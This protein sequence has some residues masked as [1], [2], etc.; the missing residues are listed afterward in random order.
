MATVQGLQAPCWC[1]IRTGSHSWG[2]NHLSMRGVIFIRSQVFIYGPNVKSLSNRH[3][4]FITSESL[5]GQNSV[6]PKLGHFINDW[7]WKSPLLWQH[8]VR[9]VPYFTI[10]H[11]KSYSV[12]WLGESV[13]AV[14]SLRLASTLVHSTSPT[15]A[16]CFL[17]RYETP[18]FSC[19]YTPVLSETLGP[20][21]M[22]AYY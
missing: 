17:L 2:A 15:R 11:A 3:H 14:I 22:N 7:W 9:F 5:H 4:I 8:T 6:Q 12:L 21:N 20:G 16:H 18:S 1:P 10:T 19:R 13:S